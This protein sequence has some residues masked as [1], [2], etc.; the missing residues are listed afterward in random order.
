[1]V[2]WV[3]TSGDCGRNNRH[4][5]DG[6]DKDQYD[7]GDLHH[8]VATDA[9][10]VVK[11]TAGV[12]TAARD[13]GAVAPGSPMMTTMM[14]MMLMMMFLMTMVTA[15]TLFATTL[16]PVSVSVVRLAGCGCWSWLGTASLVLRPT[17]PAPTNV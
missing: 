2:S 16:S 12:V 15:W 3:L 17:R 6:H 9:G 11:V 5:P 10:L 13:A 14:M 1:M 8:S 7:D 4:S